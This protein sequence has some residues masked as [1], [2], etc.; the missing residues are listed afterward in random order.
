MYWTIFERV[1][2]WILAVE[3]KAEIASDDFLT[4]NTINMTQSSLGHKS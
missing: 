1:M 3:V 4:Y 2:L